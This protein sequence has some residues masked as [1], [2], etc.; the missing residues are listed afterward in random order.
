MA[1][2][3]PPWSFYGSLGLLAFFLAIFWTPWQSACHHM[4]EQTNGRAPNKHG[5][6][7]GRAFTAAFMSAFMSEPKTNKKSGGLSAS[8]VLFRG[9]EQREE[10][11]EQ[12]GST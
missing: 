5:S 4:V 6:L 9:P 11:E 7:H 2:E 8:K 1:K 12:Q 10:D 3:V